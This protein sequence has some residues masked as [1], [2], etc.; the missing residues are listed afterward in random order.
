MTNSTDKKRVARNTFLLYIR[1]GVIMIVSLYT[2]RVVLNALGVV[3][4][5]IYT[6]VGGVVMLAS[7]LTA[8]LATASQRFI[9]FEIGRGDLLQLKRVFTASVQIHIIISLLIVLLCETVGYWMLNHKLN[10]PHDRI[11]A[12]NWVFQFSIL[13]FVTN[14]ISVPFNSLIIAHERMNAFAYVSILEALLKVFVAYLITMLSSDTLVLYAGLVF[15]VAIIIRLVYSIYCR[16]NFEESK[17]NLFQYE[18]DTFK[19]MLGFAGYNFIEVAANMFN[20]QGAAVLINMSF[21]PSLNAAR[22]ISLQV[23]SVIDSFVTSFTTAINPQITKSYAASN[24]TYMKE[25]MEKGSKYSFLLFL[26]ISVPII[27]FTQEIIQL[28]LKV[29]PDYTVLFIRLIFIDS[30]VELMTRTFYTVISAS[31]NIK[32]Y[33]IIIGILKFCNLPVCY[34]LLRYGNY[35]PQIVFYVSIMF[36]TV[37]MLLKLFL[38]KGVI[39]FDILHYV[40]KV[41]LR[42]LIVGVG[43]LLLPFLFFQKLGLHLSLISF[44]SYACLTFLYGLIIVY[45]FGLD[46][47]ERSYLINMIKNK[48]PGVKK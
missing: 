21:G 42:C 10:I 15:A 1:M 39:E 47:D 29:V 24:F 9:T 23:N 18:R 13:T 44:L 34:L 5:G 41:I 28:W 35:G 2:S 14:I 20:K 40:K 32:R 30:L 11:L 48:L 19:S 4:Y 8:S 7:M 45:I 37:I 3:D 25:L 38:I 33:Q 43:S 36:T 6:V 17:I 16:R 22:G 27:C 12:A 31:G 46:T 26:S